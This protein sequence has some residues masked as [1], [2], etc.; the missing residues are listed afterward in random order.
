[1][2]RP[3]RLVGHKSKQRAKEKIMNAKDI[4]GFRV[5]IKCDFSE[6]DGMEGIVVA[7]EDD[8]TVMVM[9]PSYGEQQFDV[10]ECFLV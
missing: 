8:S 4:I 7:A 3:G 5:C 6:A 1:M 9:L 10:T 2:G